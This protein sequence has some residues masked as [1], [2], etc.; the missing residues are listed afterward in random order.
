MDVND[1]TDGS[2]DDGDLLIAEVRDVPGAGQ[3]R[4]FDDASR[5]CGQVWLNLYAQHEGLSARYDPPA[6]R[7]VGTDGDGGP[8][9]TVFGGQD[10][11]DDWVARPWLPYLIG[12]RA[13]RPAVLWL[14]PS[15]RT[16]ELAASVR[17]YHHQGTA[18]GVEREYGVLS[19]VVTDQQDSHTFP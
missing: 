16:E 15:E 13:W 6:V 12:A 5:L 3:V 10:T 19:V 17:G 11:L 9:F 14:L 7:L 2:D 8:L 4:T 18:A 1:S